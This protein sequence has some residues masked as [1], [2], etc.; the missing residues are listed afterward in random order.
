M[1]SLR[2]TCF[3]SAPVNAD[4]S[5]LRRLLEHRGVQVLL[6]FE[7]EITGTT[8]REQIEKAINRASFCIAIIAAPPSA[9][10]LYEVGFAA[11]KAKPTLLI[12]DTMADVPQFLADLTSVKARPSQIESISYVLDTF[13][14][15]LRASV[16]KRGSLVKTKMISQR[17]KEMVEFL[18]GLGER[19]TT[20]ELE[21]IVKRVLSDSGVRIVVPGRSADQGHDMAAWVD[22]LEPVIGNPLLI[23]V[24]HK[25]TPPAGRHLRDKLLTRFREAGGRAALIIYLE[26]IEDRIARLNSAAPSAN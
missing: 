7:L 1:P 6:P 4:I 17:S 9:N 21:N 22:E 13:L 24:K 11:A 8:V 3:I 2:K 18:K 16:P 20:G 10:V 23:Q 5:K 25:L 26:G 15:K 14:D 19:A 12:L